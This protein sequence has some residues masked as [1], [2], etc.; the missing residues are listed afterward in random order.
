MSNISP[1]WTVTK[2][3]TPKTVQAT[4]SKIVYNANSVARATMI[5][6][7]TDDALNNFFASEDEVQ[8]K[9][10][11]QT[12][13]VGFIED[14]FDKRLK[15]RAKELQ[16]EVVD[17]GGYLAAKTGFERDFKRS[18][19]PDTILETMAAEIS[20]LTTNVTDLDTVS[21]KIKRNFIGTYVKDGWNAVITNA[22]GD[23]YTDESKIFQAFAEGTRELEFSPGSTFKITDQTP[24]TS[25]ELN[26]DYNFPVEYHQNAKDRYRS[27]IVTNNIKETYPN[28]VDL[29]Q[30]SGYKD[31][32]NGKTFSSYYQ[33]ASSSF[34]D[35]VIDDTTRLPVIYFPTKDV[36]GSGQVMPTIRIPV[37]DNTTN[38]GLVL[39]GI[40]YQADG[41]TRQFLDIGLNPLE[42]QFIAMYVDNQLVK[43]SGNYKIYLQLAD[44][45]GAYWEREIFDSADLP[46]SD[47][48]SGG[49]TFLEY[50]LPANLVDSPTNGWTKVLSPTTINQII[51]TTK[52]DVGFTA[53]TYMEFGK[54]HFFRR[55][56]ATS[57]GAGT[58][59]TEKVIIDS[60]A[61]SQ[62]ALQLL[63]DKEQIRANQI[64]RT[65]FFTIEGNT[66]FRNPA[67]MINTDFTSSLGT[68]RSGLVRMDQ[69]VHSLI[70]GVHKTRISFKPSNTQP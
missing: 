42:W 55:R 47:I 41:T 37:F 2:S 24:V 65:G 60:T 26:P 45:V 4:G 8:V 67:Y 46:N 9:I 17:Y 43:A 21:D 44:T 22:G 16:V 13:L 18:T 64:G 5:F 29:Y 23:Y 15:N 52:S 57:S 34:T 31:D 69:I 56:K 51:I 68:G 38:Y 3:G 62:D 30:T 63:A 59:A 36:G 32:I 50:D 12:M 11:S 70:G 40:E 54:V 19:L 7:N 10:G 27:V 58:P 39:R 49:F 35:W 25:N 1:A 6:N 53:A 20:G 28:N 61:K 66:A 48:N 33:L 14:F